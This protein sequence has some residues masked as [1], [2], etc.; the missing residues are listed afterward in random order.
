MALFCSLFSLFPAIKARIGAI[1]FS[2]AAPPF[3][4]WRVIYVNR[5]QLCAVFPGAACLICL[6]KFQY[7]GGGGGKLQGENSYP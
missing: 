1:S 7:L 4:T 6:F 2:M 3:S 5:R